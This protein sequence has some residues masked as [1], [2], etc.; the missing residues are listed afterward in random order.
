MKNLTRRLISLL[1]ALAVLACAMPAWAAPGDTELLAGETTYVLYSAAADDAVYLL[2]A[3]LWRWRVGEEQPTELMK[4]DALTP[5]GKPAM[6]FVRE[7]ALA[8]VSGTGVLGAWDGD[9][10]VWAAQEQLEWDDMQRSDAPLM[11]WPTW[12]DG[13]LY[14]MQVQNG[15]TGMAG[16]GLVCFDVASGR[17][18]LLPT[19]SLFQIAGYK[20]GKL[21]GLTLDIMA[22]SAAMA[23]G[24]SS[25]GTVV[26]LNAATGAVEQE[27]FTL[28]SL[29]DGAIA[30]DAAEDAVYVLS[31]GQVVVS[32]EGQAPVPAAY[33]PGMVGLSAVTASVLPGGYYAMGMG[34]GVSVRHADPSLLSG[35]PLSI[36][37]MGA[38]ADLM[39]RFNRDHPEI[40]IITDESLL[41]STEAIINDFVS[42]ASAADVYVLYSFQGVEA[43][44][45]KG[46]LADLSALPDVAAL[47]G[48][49]YPQV[50]DAITHGAQVVAVPALAQPSVWVV[51]D[52]L[53]AEYGLT[54]PETMQEYYQTLAYWEE[55]LAE[56]N[57]EV[58]FA[59]ITLGKEECVSNALLQYSLNYETGEAPLRLNTPVFRDALLAIEALPYEAIDLEAL[60]RGDL[61]AALVMDPPNTRYILQSTSYDAFNQG[62]PRDEDGNPQTRVI[63]P[64]PFEQGGPTQVMTILLVYVVNPASPNLESAMT[65]A[66]YAARNMPDAL[67][68]ALSPEANEPLRPAGYEAGLAQRE[69]DIAEMEAQ[70]ADAAEADQ[71]AIQDRL[72]AARLALESF[73][74]SVWQVSPEAL[75]DY[76]LVAPHINLLN[77]TSMVSMD[78][79]AGVEEINSIIMRYMAGQTGLDQA[80]T[81]LDKKLQM[82]YLE[83]E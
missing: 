14:C 24:E 76:R 19:R 63:A 73:Q 47:P 9:G 55:E 52:A 58:R 6:L 78:N 36:K 70:L 8:A 42:G 72:T 15:D 31:A 2:G 50:A 43:L 10:F 56:D 71:G 20:D 38:D 22:A 17:R 39:Q 11:L 49:L 66:A 62:A 68:V 83:A 46:Y 57:P 12:L 82:I 3:S 4:L 25:G 13:R 16:Y 67:R 51:N 33:L 53:L 40:P 79:S 32:R 21:L 65:F 28:S 23:S 45:E 74:R 54:M 75:A 30:Y 69:A 41:A 1:C 77:H 80:L 37:G 26:V 81:E 48:T 34:G 29:Q 5:E 59:N 7:G 64:L 35:N 61:S 18:E 27:L 44:K 60:A